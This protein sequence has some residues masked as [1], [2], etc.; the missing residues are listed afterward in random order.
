MAALF[1]AGLV[2]SGAPSTEA[3]GS[4]T[5]AGSGWGHRLGLSQYGAYG[6]GLEGRSWGQIIHSYYGSGVGAVPTSLP[7]SVRVGIAQSQTAA[8]ISGSGGAYTIG[9]G[10]MRWPATSG[11]WK[12]SPTSSGMRVTA[13]NGQAWDIG[14]GSVW[15]SGFEESGTV[16]TLAQNGKRY[17]R[18]WIDVVRKSGSSVNV[19][20][21]TTYDK[22]LYGLGEMPSSW[23]AASLQAQA[24]AARTYAY[25]KHATSGD[26]RTSCD[27]TVH[28][29][30]VDQAYVGWDK[31]SGSYGS[32]WVAAVNY[33]ASITILSSG[34]P[35]LALY[36]SSSGGRTDANED[37][38]GGSPL[39]YLRPMPDSWSRYSPHASWTATFSSRDLGA[40]VGL[41][42]V[43]S[44]DLSERSMGGGVATAVIQ[45]ISGGRSVTKTLSG[46]NFRSALGLRSTMV[47]VSRSRGFDQWLLLLNPNDSSVSASVSFERAGAQPVTSSYTLA[48][49][50]RTT[51]K[52]NNFVSTGDIS[53]R[54]SASKPIVAERALYFVY[55]SWDGGASGEGAKNPRNTWILAEGY[56]GR[57]F[58][59]FVEVYNPQSQQSAA[60]IDFLL[61]GGGV[62]SVPVSVPA[63]GRTTLPAY[64]VPGLHLASF[65]IRV[66]ADQPVVAERSSYFKYKSPA[67]WGSAMGGSAAIGES[68]AR[69]SWDLA[70]GYSG[71]GFDTWT[72]VANPGSAPVDVT[73]RY[74]TDEGKTV[75]Q[76]FQVP[77]NARQTTLARSLSGLSGH[78]HSVHIE[79]S[80]PVVAERAMYFQYGGIPDGHGAQGTPAPATRWYLAEGYAGPGF[81]TWV[82]ISNPASQ[83]A[84]VRVSALLDGGGSVVRDVSVA[85]GSRRT[86]NLRDVAGPVSASTMVESTNGVGIV[87]ERAS[88][89][90]YDSGRGWTATGGSDSMGVSEPSS[91]WYFAEG[92]VS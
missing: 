65:S 25:Y 10:D 18:G 23:P 2:L 15:V 89:F 85:P 53:M 29:S 52:V 32:S 60:T 36:H 17:G 57:S 11:T 79:S 5:F 40:K 69:A 35:I 1:A 9:A 54:V 88:Y 44:V 3:A 55:G 34:A 26:R 77:A 63:K 81:D 8:D 75:I 6:Q 61:E 68:E 58:D 64:G 56:Q 37:V 71:P 90:T 43:T 46:T 70:E 87:A 30:T 92:Y 33:T 28:A 84:E 83:T 50:S 19:V 21:E 47:D 27:C 39:H 51:I 86:I 16:I 42:D 80:G 78:S 13:P 12:I 66:Q 67:G 45:G 91:T 76:Q 59:T 24:V 72:L 14:V 20:V 31:E 74:L 48:A 22:Y 62:I 82:L 38:W 41:D 4:F 73:A 49:K 7:P